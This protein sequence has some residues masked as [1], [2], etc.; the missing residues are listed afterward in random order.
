MSQVLVSRGLVSIGG[1]VLLSLLGGLTTG[2][3]PGPAFKV[4]SQQTSQPFVGVTQRQLTGTLGSRRPLQVYALIIDLKAAG[5]RFLVTPAG[6]QGTTTPETTLSY[7]QRMGAQ[8]GMNANL[9]RFNLR[10]LSASVE[11]RAASQ[12]KVYGSALINFQGTINL[13]AKNQADLFLAGQIPVPPL[14]NAVS[15]NMTLI[16]EGRIVNQHAFDRSN[17]FAR[18]ALGVTA[19]RKLIML[20]VDGPPDQG[21]PRPNNR[22]VSSSGVTHVEVAQILLNQFKADAAIALDG[23]DS[24]QMVL[25]RPTCAHVNRPT[26]FT[27][28]QWSGV[29]PV[30][31]SLLVYAKAKPKL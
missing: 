21:K 1:L 5:L 16:N 18:T 9:Y 4:T 8:I 15:G 13:T 28:G 24:S 25:C 20:V 11:G 2:G 17:L 7:S 6:E 14:Y 10:T 3:Q 19:D 27:M 22:P 12:G 29:R 26:P 23:G 31:N 30:G